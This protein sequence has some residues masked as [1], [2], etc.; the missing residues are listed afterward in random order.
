MHLVP[1]HVYPGLQGRTQFIP[2]KTVPLGH[3]LQNPLI[4]EYP[5]LQTHFPANQ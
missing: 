2:L 1:V 3:L 4:L 5:G